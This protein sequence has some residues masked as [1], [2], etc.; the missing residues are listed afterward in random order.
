MLTFCPT[1]W[2]LILVICG[3]IAVLFTIYHDKIVDWLTP[4]AK[5]LK[6]QVMSLLLTVNPFQ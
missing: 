6:E 4:Y 5:D 3:V 2:Y 1:D